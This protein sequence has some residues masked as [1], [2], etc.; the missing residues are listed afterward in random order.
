[1]LVAFSP[2]HDYASLYALEVV[3]ESN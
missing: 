2:I 1:M 3:D